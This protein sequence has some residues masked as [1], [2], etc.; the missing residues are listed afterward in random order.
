MTDDQFINLTVAE[1]LEKMDM[2]EA[3]ADIYQIVGEV[4]FETQD[5]RLY[6]VLDRLLVF[7]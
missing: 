3:I 5:D 7:L 6:D 1:L 4:A 2:Q